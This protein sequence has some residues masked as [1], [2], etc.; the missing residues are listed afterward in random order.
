MS[1]AT[2]TDAMTNARDGQLPPIARDGAYDE[3]DQRSDD[4]ADHAEHGNCSNVRG[5]FA[6]EQHAEPEQTEQRPDHRA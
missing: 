4:T 5:K 1:V 2:A 3:H 6:P